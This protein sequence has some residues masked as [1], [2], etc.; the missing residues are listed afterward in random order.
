MHR[1]AAYA[2]MQYYGKSLEDAEQVIKLQPSLP[3]GHSRKGTALLGMGQARE[4]VSAFGEALRLDPG[5]EVA[6][7]GLRSAKAALQ[8]THSN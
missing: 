8:R 7:D 5:N 3:K 6:A 1:A 4:A 2:G